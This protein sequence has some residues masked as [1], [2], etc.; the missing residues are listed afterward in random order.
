MVRRDDNQQ[1]ADMEEDYEAQRQANIKANLE[2]MK[3]LGLFQ[4]SQMIKPP[5]APKCKPTP[6]AKAASSSASTVDDPSLSPRIPRPR[7]I[8][9][10]VSRTLESPQKP[11]GMKRALSDTSIP[12]ADVRKTARRADDYDDLSSS[13]DDDDEYTGR[14]ST[15]RRVSSISGPLNPSRAYRPSSELQRHA[16]RLGIRIHNPK[17][18]GHI[19]GIPIGTLWSKR[20]D[21]STDAVH[22]PT[23][24]GISGNE[25][26]GCWSIC[27]SGGYEDDV[28]LGETFTYTGSGGRDLKGTANNPKNLRTAP[29]SSDQRWDGKNAALKR[30][31]AT[32]KPVRV[33]R[34]FKA[35][36]R[37]APVEGY[38]YSGLYRVEEAWMERG[39][40]GWKVCKFRF[41]RLGGQD[42]LPTF[43]RDEE[44]DEEQSEDE[45]EEEQE[46]EEQKDSQTLRSTRALRRR[47]STPHSPSPPSPTP[48]AI[49]P[50]PILKSP[51]F[52]RSSYII[53]SDTEAEACESEHEVLL[54]LELDA[55]VEM[56]ERAVRRSVRETRNRTVLKW[57]REW[58][59]SWGGK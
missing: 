37:Y 49:S 36:N 43:D 42:P 47:S 33:V 59:R 46:Q 16:D 32:R 54:Q 39:A 35:A 6:K 53:V 10:S 19:P 14:S 22:A 41:V 30:S 4:G 55:A 27:L 11:R 20:M 28:D 7:R 15:R 51:T 31:V 24:A 29:Q 40:A 2:L 50:H 17:T 26:V 13:D 5:T 38:V 34:G 18:F 45:V 58:S 48:S 3:S 23:V 9:R 44:A 25:E 57:G 8:T 52:D 12:Y 21:C 56:E 1:A